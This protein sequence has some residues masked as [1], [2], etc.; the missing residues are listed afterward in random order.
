MF[1]TD[2]HCL[3][4]GESASALDLVYMGSLTSSGGL[5]ILAAR[6]HQ[7]DGAVQTATSKVS[8]TG[9]VTSEPVTVEFGS[10]VNELSYL[11]YGAAGTDVADDP[12]GDPVIITITAGDTTLSIGLV[13]SEI[14]ARMFVTQ[15]ITNPIKSKEVVAGKYWQNT[16]RKIKRYSPW[17]FSIT[18]GAYIFIFAPG[19]GYSIGDTLTI[20]AGGQS[21]TLVITSIGGAGIVHAWTVTSNTF[22]VP[23]GAIAATGGSGA[24]A[25]FQVIIVP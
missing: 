15:I 1:L 3:E 23:Q 5:P 16:S 19:A 4:T 22:T 21:A 20:T 18:P 8:N 12:I 25:S 10:L 14:I 13:V 9:L 6:Q 2:R 7:F 11:S 24:G 17:I